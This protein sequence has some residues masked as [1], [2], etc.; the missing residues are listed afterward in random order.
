MEP[1]NIMVI[2]PGD[3]AHQGA[4]EIQDLEIY[5][6]GVGTDDAQAG[7]PGL[8]GFQ[9]YKLALKRRSTLSGKGLAAVTRYQ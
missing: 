1:A 5:Y 3:P 7:G 2:N 8:G 6:R 4:N 9:G